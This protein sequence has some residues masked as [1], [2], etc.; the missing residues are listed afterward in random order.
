MIKYQI[1]LKGPWT[2]DYRFYVDSFA[3]FALSSPA[4]EG[5]SAGLPAVRCHMYKNDVAMTVHGNAYS[6]EKHVCDS[7][8]PFAQSE[9]R[10]LRRTTKNLSV[11]AIQTRHRFE[12]S[13]GEESP[14]EWVKN[15]AAGDIARL[16]GTWV[17]PRGM[18]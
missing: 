13:E 5:S 14:V 7:A 2:D 17:D 11:L 15:Q 8:S 6:R 10:F 12:E 9:S 16:L 1:A 18:T 4:A 3:A